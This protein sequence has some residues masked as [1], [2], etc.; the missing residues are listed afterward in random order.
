MEDGLVDNCEVEGLGLILCAI[1]KL[2]YHLGAFISRGLLNTGSPRE[3][4]GLAAACTGSQFNRGSLGQN[5]LTSNVLHR[6]GIG[7]LVGQRDELNAGSR[8]RRATLY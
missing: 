8:E 3:S 6:V 4:N 7:S 5:R 2:K 1:G